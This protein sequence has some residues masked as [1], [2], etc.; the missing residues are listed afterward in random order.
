[1]SSPRIASRSSCNFSI[2]CWPFRRVPSAMV[3]DRCELPDS[4]R[5]LR[6]PLDYLRTTGKIRGFYS[7]A[8]PF[9][10]VT[11]FAAAKAWIRPRS[12]DFTAKAR[13][14]R[15][16]SWLPDLL[17]NVHR[18][19][20]AANNNHAAAGNREGRVGFYERT[21]PP[22]VRCSNRRRRLGGSDTLVKPLL[23]GM[24]TRVELNKKI[25]PREAECFTDRWMFIEGFGDTGE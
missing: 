3:S 5:E 9:Q 13:S 11:R 23:S 6:F 2:A 22:I 14:A 21:Q 12:R 19:Q 1:M 25:M 20:I 17:P 18:H 16:L 10:H 4:S 8:N 24:T 7:G 15:N